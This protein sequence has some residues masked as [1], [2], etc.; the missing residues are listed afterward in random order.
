[1]RG[2]PLHNLKLFYNFKSYRTAKLLFAKLFCILKAVFYFV[3][4]C[5]SASMLLLIPIKS[6]AYRGSSHSDYMLLKYNSSGIQW[7]L[8]PW[9]YLRKYQF[10]P[11]LLGLS[12]IKHF[13]QHFTTFL[14]FKQILFNK[15]NSRLLLNTSLLPATKQSLTFI[16]Y[17][18][19]WKSNA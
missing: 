4:K 12:S 10:S 18:I 14:L 13:T 9:S 2:N 6:R 1:M 3:W 5:L 11:S 17:K 15:T 16:I 19:T 8:W 7:D